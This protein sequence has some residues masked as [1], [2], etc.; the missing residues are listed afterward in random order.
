M[1]DAGKSA[2][3]TFEHLKRRVYKLLLISLN[4]YI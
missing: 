3:Y 2:F 1:A 4:I